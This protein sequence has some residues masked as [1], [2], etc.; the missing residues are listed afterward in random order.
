MCPVDYLSDYQVSTSDIDTGELVSFV[1][2]AV[3]IKAE[4]KHF[5]ELCCWLHHRC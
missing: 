3:K 4:V 2:T 1:V 5:D